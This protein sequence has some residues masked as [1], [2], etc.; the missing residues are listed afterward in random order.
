MLY[1]ARLGDTADHHVSAS[2]ALVTS[3][4]GIRGTCDHIDGLEDDNLQK[5]SYVP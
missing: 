5:S 2:S 1:Q 4:R 3:S